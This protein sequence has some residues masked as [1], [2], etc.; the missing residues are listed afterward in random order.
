MLR[1]TPGPGVLGFLSQAE[2][3]SEVVR[4]LS[5]ALTRAAGAH[6]EA[7]ICF[8]PIPFDDGKAGR[9]SDEEVQ[10]LP[11]VDQLTALEN[12][13]SKHLRRRQEQTDEGESVARLRH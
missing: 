13:G 3:A 4:L 9:S 12:G 5:C 2:K 7:C 8:P 11:S 6:L 10:S 1:R